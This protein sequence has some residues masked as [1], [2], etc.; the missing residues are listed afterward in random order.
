[1]IRVCEPKCFDWKMDWRKFLKLKSAKVGIIVAALLCLLIFVVP[2]FLPFSP[3]VQTTSEKLSFPSWRHP[4]GTDQYGRDV[5]ARIADGGKRSLGA[6]ALVLSTTVF[7]GLVIGVAVGMSGGIVDAAVMRAV[8]VL[9]ALPQLVL[10]LAIVGVLG[11]GFENLLIALTISFLGFYVRFAR[12]L[13]AA[14]RRRPDVIVA[15]LAGI[16]WLRIIA[17]HVVPGV[18]GQMLILATLDLGSVIISLAG[19]SF[20]GL[21]VQPPSAEW[22]VMLKESRLFFTVAPWL[23]LAP[24]T[25]IFLSV[26]AANLIGNALRDQSETKRF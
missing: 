8:D 22:G 17:G 20:L 4:F 13:T 19:L 26:A 21:G 25:T 12:S 18:F 5:L 23:L 3:N 1:M 14:A 6:A 10:A 11:V 24:G 15:R 7:L 2:L 16:G 9:L